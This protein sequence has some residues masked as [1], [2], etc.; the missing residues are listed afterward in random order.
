MFSY[1]SHCWKN[2]KSFEYKCEVD[3]LNGLRSYSFHIFVD[4]KV[5]DI[6]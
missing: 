3:V 4:H 6:Q 1:F 2:E 5:N